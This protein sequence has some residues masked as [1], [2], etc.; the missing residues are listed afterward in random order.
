MCCAWRWR[1]GRARAPPS[2]SDRERRRIGRSRPSQFPIEFHEP[3]SQRLREAVKLA[4]E[5]AV[6]GT[7]LR[8]LDPHGREAETAQVVRTRPHIDL[9]RTEGEL[10]GVEH[11]PGRAERSDLVG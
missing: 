2:R 4:L 8:G 10:E 9:A 5:F 7:P 11:Q 1:K 6:F 3:A